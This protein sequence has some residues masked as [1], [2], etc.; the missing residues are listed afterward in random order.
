VI[1]TWTGPLKGPAA[2][3]VVKVGA[4]A[5]TVGPPVE[6]LELLEELEELE[7]EE[8]LEE[9]LVE[10]P[11]VLDELAELLVELVELV[12]VPGSLSSSPPQA[13]APVAP[14]T[15]SAARPRPR[16]LSFNLMPIVVL[17]LHAKCME[18]C[19]PIGAG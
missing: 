14:P 1:V 8:L 12:V 11:E 18:Q 2:G 6:L 7:L 10:E 15:I 4:A 19:G 17:P 5:C 16:K 3:L 13:T 9:L